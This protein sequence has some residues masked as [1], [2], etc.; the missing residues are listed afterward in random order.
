MKDEEVHT[1]SRRR[2]AAF[3]TKGNTLSEL[4]LYSLRF[5]T[6]DRIH[7]FYVSKQFTELVFSPVCHEIA[8]SIACLARL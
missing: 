3:H 6:I 5:K 7:L 2:P 4:G 8:P 1:H